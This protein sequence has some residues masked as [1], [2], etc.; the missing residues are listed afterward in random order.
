M[1]KIDSF[2]NLYS[3]PKTL[4]FRAI[5]VGKTQENITEKKLLEEDEERSE[6]YREAKKIIDRFHLAFME[7]ILSNIILKDLDNYISLFNKKDKD[8]NEKKLLEEHEENLR[9]QIS[10]A[11]KN[12]PQYKDLFGESLIK[13]ILPSFL[14]DEEEQNIIRSFVGFKTAFEGFNQNRANMYSEE[15]KS[16]AV[17]Y[18]CINENL[19]RY[20]TNMN[21]FKSIRTTL[22]ENVLNVINKDIGMEPYRL[23]DCFT[24]D[25][26]N[27]VLS[28][29]GIDAYN[30]FLGGFTRENGEKVK[31]LNEYIN[32]HNQ[33]LPK[34]DKSK[35]LPKLNPLYKQMLA[36]HQGISFYVDG[37]ES[38]QAALDDI[39]KIA[40]EGSVFFYAVSKFSKLFDN[41]SEYLSA[42]IYIQNGP[43]LTN[44]SQEITGY[45]GTVQENWNRHYDDEVMK[46]PPKDME[47][48]IEK[49]RK[50]FKSIESFSLDEVDQFISTGS[51]SGGS[52]IIIDYLTK[53]ADELTENISEKYDAVKDVFVKPYPSEKRLSNDG[54]TIRKIKDFLDAIKVFETF[55]KSLKGT[56]K[57]YGRDEIF[58]GDFTEVYD[59][60]AEVD[61]LY[62][63]VRNY[64]TKKYYSKDKYKLYFQN[65]QFMGGWDRNK[66]GDYRSTL[67]RKDNVYYL[68][69]IDKGNS[70]VLNDL[71]EAANGEYYE[72]LDYKLIPG[73]SKS[74]PHV[75]MSGKGIRDFNPSSK[76]QD[77][78][79]KKTFIKGNNFNIN[80]CHLL[81]DYFKSAISSHSWQEE[82]DFHFS[83]T[84]LYKDI[85]GFY[86]EVDQQGYKLAFINVSKSAIDQLVEEGKVYLFQLFSKDFSQ[87]SKGMKNLHTMYFEQLFNEENNGGIKLCGGAELFYRKSSIRE[88]E[89]IIHEA[90]KAIKNKN[91]LN[92]NKE[93]IFKYDIIKNRRYTVDQYEIHIPI[94]LNRAPEN[95]S[96]INDEV[97]K[98]IRR[99]DNP[100]VIGIDRGERNLLYVCVIDGK[101]NIVEQKTLNEIVNHYNGGEIRTDYHDLLD[102]R[103]AESK[104]AR[105][106][107]SS[108]QNIKELKEGYISQVIHY[109]CTLVTRY[110][111]VI[112]MEDLSSGF[113]N[114]RKKVEKQVYQKFEKALID[115]LNYMV[116][117]TIPIGEKG[118][119]TNGYQ[120]ANPFQSF[121]AI[122]KQNGFIFYIPAWLT[123]KIDPV[124]GFADLLKPKYTSVEK[125]R[126]FIRSF[127]SIQYNQSSD[128]FEFET[129]FRKFDRTDADYKK[130]WTICTYG[131]R[132]KTFRDPGRNNEWNHERVILTE[133]FKKLFVQYGI[134]YENG[135]LRESVC[136]MGEK[137]FY[138]EFVFL[139]RLTVQ[140]RNSI[141]GSIRPEDD[142][143][144][145]PVKSESGEFYDS[146]HAMDNLP[147][148]ADANGAYNIARKVLW[149]IEQFRQSAEEDVSKTRIAISNKEWLEFAQK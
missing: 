72:L 26:F 23:E 75:F 55:I 39:Y 118:S 127:D 146:R 22:G 120:L 32:L 56:G 140:M 37:Y 13:D 54:E 92:P 96:K 8:D 117:K 47:K 142:Y 113:K 1:K 14:R 98:A 25:F 143:L 57:E 109:L 67:L 18:R 4:R 124:T 145:S 135:D 31:G 80:D 148:D 93:S 149:A 105:Q 35:R 82:Y 95:K 86:K 136:A 71:P 74:L 42:G 81:I 144:I 119:V 94:I 6:K 73:A 115:K 24:V 12:D 97:R 44:L 141:T 16:T 108:I 100:Y 84:S 126:D 38:D 53:K 90:N 68:L 61:H 122:G 59:G 48:Y 30:T 139:F 64:A 111:A 7:R 123:S 121:K 65:P 102:R 62:D 134:P 49:R 132:I 138:E 107:W 77:L 5:P 76:V 87:N 70:K 89:R 41:L 103:E 101:G 88:N 147:K 112:A 83:D 85:S 19:P 58:Y 34:E 45:W 11:F 91:P 133:A 63:R 125:A 110:D 27:F 3:V 2:I 9:K 78:Y 69:I 51:E 79:K 130:I 114:S 17:S 116:D 10:D 137:S 128:Y 29:K 99:D 33:Q 20:I 40:G 43:A 106:D 50:A 46:K 129:D 52:H 28:G 60:M 21:N 104:K 66:I 36:E 131:D 15:A